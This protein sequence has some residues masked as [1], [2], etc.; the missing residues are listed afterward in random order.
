MGLTNL[1]WRANCGLNTRG[2]IYH[3]MSRGKKRND[4]NCWLIR[5]EN[6]QDAM[7]NQSN[8]M[9][10][11]LLLPAALLVVLLSGIFW[12]RT[13][14]VTIGTDAEGNATIFGFPMKSPATRYRV[15]KTLQVLGVHGTVE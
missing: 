13:T 14:G 3:V 2:T 4:L 6:R 5:L 15:M 7:S 11:W 8:S 1:S 12:L 9:M 10:Q